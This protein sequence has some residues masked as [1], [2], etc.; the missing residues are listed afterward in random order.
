MSLITKIAGISLNSC[1]MNA[2]GCHC[3]TESELNELNESKSGA[4]VSKSSTMEFRIGNIEPRLYY[5]INGSINSMGLPNLGYKFYMDYNVKQIDKLNKPFIQSIHPFSLEDFNIMKNDLDTIKITRLVE[6]NISCPNIQNGEI[7]FNNYE[8]YMD[9]INQSRLQNIIIGLKLQP[10][11]EVNYFNTISSLLFKYDIKFITCV[12]SLP[13]GLIIDPL[14]ET[15]KISNKNGLG[16]IGGGYLKP[17]GLANV[18]N[19][20]RLLNDK[21]D[22]IGCGGIS[23]GNDVFEYILCGARAVQV[24]TN[25]IKLGTNC[26]EKLEDELLNIM[27]I[28]KYDNI[29]M[30]HNK[31]KLI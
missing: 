2:S 13:N 27:K 9:N 29:D 26:F 4:I 17:I 24:G 11:L 1:I 8:K 30:F 3:M 7:S 12:N 14:S 5:D 23:T 25:L 22:I 21:V 19:F 6:L 15:T 28:K 31:I 18:F 10:F 16:G 20:S